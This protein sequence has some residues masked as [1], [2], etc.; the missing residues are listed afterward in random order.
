MTQQFAYAFGF[1]GAV[2]MLAS[3]WMKSMLPLRV[4]ALVAC[5]FLVVYGFLMQALPTLLLY[6]VL[7]PINLKKTWEM[8]QLVLAIESAQADTPVSQW[9]LPHMH[10]QTVAAGTQLWAKGDVADHMLYLERGTLLLPEY[11]ERLI[12]GALVGEIGLFARQGQRTLSLQAET[13]CVLYRLTREEMVLLYHQNPK[14]GF[15]V[16]RLV[17]ERLMHD[18]DKARAAAA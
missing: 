8:R 10:R 2:L 7:I 6:A 13:D 12:E 17:V 9:L 18:A 16:M 4:V 15:H 11:G 1:L 3:Y 14:L 5:C